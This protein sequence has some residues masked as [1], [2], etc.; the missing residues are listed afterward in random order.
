MTTN[1]NSIRSTK[2]NHQKKSSSSIV[3]S[4]NNSSVAV[5]SIT[6]KKQ[7]E[8]RMR[9]IQALVEHTLGALNEKLDFPLDISK[10]D[11]LLLDLNRLWTAFFP[12]TP[13]PT[14]QE[15]EGTIEHYWFMCAIMRGDDPS[16]MLGHEREQPPN[17]IF[18]DGR[19]NPQHL[20]PQQNMPPS[21]ELSDGRL[22]PQYVEWGFAQV[23]DTENNGYKGKPRRRP[24]RLQQVWDALRPFF[25]RGE[26]APLQALAEPFI[27]SNRPHTN[28]FGRA[29]TVVSKINKAFLDHDI[30]LEIERYVTY[31]IQRRNQR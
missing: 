12:H 4:R 31:Q 14:G 1:A 8:K 5:S 20:E 25:Y 10:E 15:P 21:V 11:L 24:F 7:L 29:Q 30:D 3:K 27:D 17:T 9:A 26:G 6:N 23:I 2:S 22:N 18:P 13:F 16:D 19:L 28:P